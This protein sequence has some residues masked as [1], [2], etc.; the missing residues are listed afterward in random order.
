MKRRVAALMAALSLALPMLVASATPVAALH[1]VQGSC[2]SSDHTKVFARESS[3]G[4]VEDGD[5][6]WSCGNA[7]SMPSHTLPGS[8]DANATWD[9]CISN[10]WVEL[11]EGYRFCAYSGTNYTGT[12]LV[13]VVNG[14]Y[15]GVPWVGSP[16]AVNNA[17]SSH[18]WIS[19][20]QG[21]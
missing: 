10:A 18:R 21:C 4:N 2:S 13:S 5:A 11:T 19:S 1:V 6:L 16:P 15:W 3:S 12:L 7:T 20:M 9:N 17:W 8:C 14:P